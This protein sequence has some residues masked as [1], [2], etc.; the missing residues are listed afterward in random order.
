MKRVISYSLYGDIKKYTYG[1]VKNAEDIPLYYP[2]WEGWFYVDNT[3]P[4]HIIRK[5]KLCGMKIINM[6][7][8]KYPIAMM[9]RFLVFGHKDVNYAIVRDTD[10]RL[11][12]R[13]SNAVSEWI[14]SGKSFHIM[15]D[16][17]LHDVL[18]MGG[19]WGAKAGKLGDIDKLIKEWH[20]EKADSADQLFLKDMIYPRARSDSFIH[21]SF[22]AYEPHAG[23]FSTKREGLNFVGE[24]FDENDKPNKFDT[25]RLKWEGYGKYRRLMNNLLQT[26]FNLQRPNVKRAREMR[27]VHVSVNLS[28]VSAASRL[29]MSE[30]LVGI[31]AVAL[32]R[33]ANHVS[34]PYY[35]N[36]S[37]IGQK[38][39][40][41]YIIAANK[42][43]EYKHRMLRVVFNEPDPE[44]PW[45]DGILGESVNKTINKLGA[46]IVHLHWIATGFPA[47]GNIYK[48][49]KPIVWTFHDVW[50]ITSGHHCEMGCEGCNKDGKN[51]TQFRKSISLFPSPEYLWKYK[52]KYYRKIKNLTIITPSNW[53]GD[54]VKRNPLFVGRKVFV[55][56]NCIDTEM[57]RPMEKR[58]VRNILNLPPDKKIILFSAFGGIDIGYK[59]FDLLQ[60]ALWSL[61]EKVG[62]VNIHLIILGSSGSNKISLPYPATFLGQVDTEL[63]LPVIYNAADVFVGPS[64]QDNFPNV[65][66][67]AVSCGI[68]C[69]GFNVGGIPEIIKHKQRG[70]IAKSFDTNDLANGIHWILDHKDYASLSLN[71]R[72]FAE[73]NLSF[74][75]ISE[76]HKQLYESL[77]NE[78]LNLE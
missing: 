26:L 15:R 7:G 1:A 55:I 73:D 20:G 60:D 64:R 68:P 52:Q 74:S 36:G 53:L 43:L 3:V 41:L 40:N 34:F 6:D 75:V 47:V 63:M 21:A 49:K 10:S 39:V 57:F 71:C 66:V 48:I 59:G 51:C 78:N 8:K 18:M 23:P 33:S 38:F 44:N 14:K 31:D 19:L 42:Y 65:F 2:G 69:V 27:I 35:K 22:N 72:K 30:R 37:T 77:I 16:H 76:K 13:E 32:V 11:S 62:L 17:P 67:E 56:P 25:A 61:R 5:L 54:K 29:I 70:Y 28:P 9:W 4:K 12:V 46:D 58:S 24:I 45:N 50:P